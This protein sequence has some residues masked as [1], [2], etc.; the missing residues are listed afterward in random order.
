MLDV[1]LCVRVKWLQLSCCV[2]ESTVCPY[3]LH[4]LISITPASQ[5]HINQQG[6]QEAWGRESVHPRTPPIHT[7]THPPIRHSGCKLSPSIT[8]G[9]LF[10]DLI[11]IIIQAGRSET[12]CTDRTRHVCL[13]HGPVSGLDSLSVFFLSLYPSQ[14]KWRIGFG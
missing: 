4:P 7:H 11:F 8:P 12:F 10:I 3:A 13:H 14:V 6:C 9:L 5:V 1:R 2:T